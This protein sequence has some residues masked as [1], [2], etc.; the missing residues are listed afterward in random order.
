MKEKALDKGL[1]E[2]IDSLGT[3]LTV[4]N[5]AKIWSDEYWE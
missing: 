1:V 2:V 3:D 5:P 4:A